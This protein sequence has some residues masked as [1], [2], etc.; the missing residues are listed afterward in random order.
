MIPTAA[1]E[2]PCLPGCP[3][4]VRWDYDPGTPATY[5]DPPEPPWLEAVPAPGPAHEL[6]DEDDSVERHLEVMTDW[7]NDWDPDSPAPDLQRQIMQWERAEEMGAENR[8][9]SIL[10]LNGHMAANSR[11]VRTDPCPDDLADLPF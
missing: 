4:R 6:E 2:T 9:N 5:W 11:V 7:V 10:Y 1:L 3:A 8:L